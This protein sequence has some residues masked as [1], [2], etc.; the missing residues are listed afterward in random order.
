VLDVCDD[1]VVG[2]D[3][4]GV[5]ILARSQLQVLIYLYQLLDL[6]LAL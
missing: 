4:D 2:K 1:F 3:S 5:G 6:D